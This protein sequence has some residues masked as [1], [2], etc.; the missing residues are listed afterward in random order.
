MGL[1]MFLNAKR[2]IWL[3]ED[4]LASKVAEL[5]PELQGLRVKE[6]L[7]EAAY[8]RKSNWLHAWFVKNVQKEVDDCGHYKVEREQLE[9]LR[10]LILKAL[11]TRD[12]SL[13]PPQSGFFFGSTD[14]NEHYWAD[15][16]DTEVTLVKVMDD[17]PS[18]W[19]FEYHASW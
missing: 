19:D 7:V 14:V 9:Q 5:L 18:A 15:L 11:S 3:E 13:L 12:A 2:Y 4:E 17:L 10:Q 16:R 8:W 6:I 1:D